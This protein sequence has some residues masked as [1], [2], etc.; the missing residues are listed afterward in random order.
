[1]QE[2]K[3]W[4]FNNAISTKQYTRAKQRHCQVLSWHHS[5]FLASRY[6]MWPPHKFPTLSLAHGYKQPKKSSS[7]SVVW[8][9]PDVTAAGFS[10]QTVFI[11]KHY[12]NSLQILKTGSLSKHRPH[13]L[14]SAITLNLAW[15][16]QFL[17]IPSKYPPRL[18]VYLTIETPL[19]GGWVPPTQPLKKDS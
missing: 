8:F 13:Y 16:A 11:V 12:T 3:P 7:L 4:H 2:A 18:H 10:N 15:Y 17:Q 9:P 19:E 14:T 1:M 6:L 5:T